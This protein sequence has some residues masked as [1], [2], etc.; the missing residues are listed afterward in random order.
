M[1]PQPFPNE[2]PRHVSDEELPELDEVTSVETER[3]SNEEPRHTSDEELKELQASTSAERETL[4][5]VSLQLEF[6]PSG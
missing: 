6:L 3:N 5:N 2:E 1:N 4:I